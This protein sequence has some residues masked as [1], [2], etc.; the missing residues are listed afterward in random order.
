M[1]ITEIALYTAWIL[2]D[3]IEEARDFRLNLKCCIIQQFQ[4]RVGVF[5][6]LF[7]EF[8]FHFLFST[9][10]EIELRIFKNKEDLVERLLGFL[11]TLRAVATN[12]KEILNNFLQQNTDVD[13]DKLY[14]EVF[15]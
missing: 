3:G 7:I 6:W 11:G 4:Q 2:Y 15:L 10:N 9:S 12:H 8:L 1:S 5:C 14:K 13:L